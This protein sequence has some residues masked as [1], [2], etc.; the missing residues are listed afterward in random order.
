MVKRACTHCRDFDSGF[1]LS[2]GQPDRLVSGYDF[3]GNVCGAGD[4]KDRPYVYYPFPYPKDATSGS[5]DGADFTWAVCVEK[6]PRT[7]LGVTTPPNMCSQAFRVRTEAASQN[8]AVGAG[9]K[10]VVVC[11]GLDGGQTDMAQFGVEGFLGFYK[12]CMKHK[13][14]CKCSGYADACTSDSTTCSPSCCMPSNATA[15]DAASVAIGMQ[16]LATTQKINETEYPEQ[17][18]FGIPI[19]HRYGF[20]WVPYPSYLPGKG[21][22]SWTRCMPFFDPKDTGSLNASMGTVSSSLALNTT[23]NGDPK[24]MEAAFKAVIASMSGP[25]ETA[26]SLVNQVR[27]YWVQILTSAFIALVVSVVYTYLLKVAAGPLIYT[28]MALVWVMLS[29]ACIVLCVKAAF[30]DPSSIPG[31]S[32]VAQS[33]PSGVSFG[34][35]QAN[36]DLVVAGAVVLAILWVVYNLMLC[37]LIPRIGVAVK[38]MSVASSCLA[39]M[40]T[41]LLFPV[42][43]WVLTFLLYIYFVIVLW[44]LASAG[45]W[46]ADE[47]RYVWEPNLQRLMLMH[48]FGTLWSHAFILAV[49]NLVIAGAAADW[50]LTE[51]KK[52]LH[53]PA[54]A[55]LKRTVRYH[56]GTAAFG[57][58][59]IAIVQLVRWVFRYYM[60][61]LNKLS[62]DSSIVKV[63]S[64]I[65]ECCLDC[66]ERFLDFINKNAYVQTAITAKGFVAAA[67]AATQL[68]LRNCLRV[69]TLNIVSSAFIFL[70][71]YLIA[72]TT[73]LIAALWIAN[74]DGTGALENVSG[75]P[76]FPVLVIVC[77]AFGVACAFLDVW[78]MVIDTIFQCYCMDEELG[79]NKSPGEIKQAVANNPPSE[80]DLKGIGATV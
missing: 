59:L 74:A 66:L 1:G 68:L 60:Y 37:V 29:G 72:L 6:C 23:S 48:F 62:P 35:A 32:T 63:L 55:S 75:A 2:R 19:G 77:L 34:P 30:I 54:V 25:R 53:L 42:L 12:Y 20:C 33:L 26:M 31:S 38:I 58:L 64:C 46:D 17:S 24:S 14:V 9:A 16:M 41:T 67:C 61:Q 70:G 5:L 78:D 43:S 13:P 22:S 44:Y 79:T 73:G 51:D 76:V 71:K 56:L 8:P 49:G 50:F 11:G 52:V 15:T 28:G 3:N 47:H 10:P 80:S 45:T 40:P 36:K 21:A 27:K 18:Q 4:M 39:A 65:G 7:P 57:S 69:G